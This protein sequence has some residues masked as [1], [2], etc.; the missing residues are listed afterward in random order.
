[1]SDYNDDDLDT[2]DDTQ[3][4]NTDGK[5]W[6]KQL[7]AERAEAKAEAQRVK[8]EADTA[9]RELAFLKAGVDLDTPQGKLLAKAYDGDPTPEAVK[10]YAEEYGVL[11]PAAAQVPVEELQAHERVAAASAG[12]VTQSQADLHMSAVNNAQSI[13]ELMQALAAAD[14][15]LVDTVSKPVPGTWAVGDGNTPVT[16][17]S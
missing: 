5:G 3:A 8:A 17:P 16:T 10:A 11:Q 14:P 6:R 13:G 4:A 12:A 9:R 1:M 2:A 15:D 7:E